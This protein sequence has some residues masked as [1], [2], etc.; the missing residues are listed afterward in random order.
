MYL[1]L[2]K[3]IQSEFILFTTRV[4]MIRSLYNHK[5]K[6][7]NKYKYKHGVAWVEPESAMEPKYK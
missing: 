7:K 4:A 1:Y 5:H 2:C 3:N 6:H